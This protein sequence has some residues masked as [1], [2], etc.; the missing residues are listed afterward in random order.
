MEST[1]YLKNIKITPK[2]LRFILDDVKKHKPV[3]AVQKLMYS[4]NKAG[5]LLYK[6]LMSAMVNAKRTLNVEESMLQ[7]K[8]LVIEEG[9]KIRRYRAGGRGTAKPIK[10]R[11]A[12]IKIVLIA[13]SPLSTV[14]K[15]TEKQLPE[16][17]Q[18]KD[19]IVAQSKEQADAALKTKKPAVR[20]TTKKVTKKKEAAEA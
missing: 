6:A 17:A 9:Q 16:E 19:D 14:T 7:F 11:F 20:K 2:K 18:K 3:D 15:K 4:S 10:R 1:T 12:H 5:H 13:E 8:T